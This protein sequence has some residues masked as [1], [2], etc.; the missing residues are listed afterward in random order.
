MNDIYNLEWIDE[1]EVMKNF[2]T[3]E[4]CKILFFKY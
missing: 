1:E 2:L 3:L 4:E